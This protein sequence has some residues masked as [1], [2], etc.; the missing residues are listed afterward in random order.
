MPRQKLRDAAFILPF[1]GLI[2]I[3]PPFVDIFFS[4]RLLGGI[5][6]IL[7]Y[8][9]GVWTMLIV[10]GAILSRRLITDGD[11]AETPPRPMQPP[12]QQERPDADR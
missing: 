2:L 6:G 4:T 5:P 9:F 10:L 7:L 12:P 3:M 8:I 11:A 1:F